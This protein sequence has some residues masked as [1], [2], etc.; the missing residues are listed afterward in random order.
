MLTPTL[1]SLLPSTLIYCLL[2]F[3]LILIWVSLVAMSLPPGVV[4]LTCQ[5]MTRTGGMCGWGGSGAMCRLG[6]WSFISSATFVSL[7]PREQV[8]SAS[9]SGAALVIWTENPLGRL[10]SGHR[11]L[12]F[13]DDHNQMT[14]MLLSPPHPPPSNHTPTSVANHSLGGRSV[15]VEGDQLVEGGRRRHLPRGTHQSQIRLIRA[16]MMEEKY[17]N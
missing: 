7:H 4:C 10:S 16:P 6:S 14:I 15:E 9:V 12:V 13:Q 11:C 17:I 1:T 3:I 5:L 8:T 2:H